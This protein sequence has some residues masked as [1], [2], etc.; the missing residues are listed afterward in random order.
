MSKLNPIFSDHLL[1]LLALPGVLFACGMTAA[2]VVAGKSVAPLWM[3]LLVILVL[4][5]I[6]AV[7]LTIPLHFVAQFMAFRSAGYSRT[8]T[9]FV[10]VGVLCA[11]IA[12][13]WLYQ[14]VG[15]GFGWLFEGS[16]FYLIGGAA[17]VAVFLVYYS[18]NLY[19][20]RNKLNVI[21]M[22]PSGRTDLIK[23]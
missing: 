7:V 14:L 16:R 1:P 17:F 5:F 2:D 18:Y 15:S 11:I 6:S 19:A 4:G 20:D 13:G 8:Q 23:N 10:M 21:N 9:V 22:T 3:T 12:A